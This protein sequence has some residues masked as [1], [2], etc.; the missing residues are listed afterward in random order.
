MSLIYVRNFVAWKEKMM[1][2][3]NGVELK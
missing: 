2:N 1:K 3:R